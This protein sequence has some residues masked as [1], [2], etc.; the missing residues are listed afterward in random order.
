MIDKRDKY[1]QLA[2]LAFGEKLSAARRAAG[3]TQQELAQMCH[4][5]PRWLQQIEA[6]KAQ[7]DLGL[8]LQ[9]MA[10]FK[11][12]INLI[13]EEVGLM[14]RYIAVSEKLETPELGRYV[15]YGIAGFDSGDIDT[16]PVIF[17][18]DV[19]T[20][21]IFVSR[22]AEICTLEQLHPNHLLDVIFNAI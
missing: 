10:F 2:A 17:I 6:G 16:S 15:T 11:L 21:A 12:D 1:K 18:S 7:P 3:F 22:L 9:L 14:V 20:D 19:S 13:A 8:T 5:T 4:I